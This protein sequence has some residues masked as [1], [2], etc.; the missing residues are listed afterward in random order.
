MERRIVLAKRPDLAI[1]LEK[2]DL[3]PNYN[4]ESPYRGCAK[5]WARDRIPPYD[6]PEYQALAERLP[7]GW[8]ELNESELEEVLLKLREKIDQ[9]KR[10]E[11][12]VPNK[13]GENA[14]RNLVHTAFLAITSAS[15]LLKEKGWEPL[16]NDDQK[17]VKDALEFS[18]ELSLRLFERAGILDRIFKFI[19]SAANLT[20]EDRALVQQVLKTSALFLVVFSASGGEREKLKFYFSNI[21]PLVYNGIVE[22]DRMVS[23]R[24]NEGKIRGELA[25]TTALFLRS[26]T[27]ALE[28]ADFDGFYA[29]FE[30]LLKQIGVDLEKLS[31]ETQEL[32]K[33]AD[34]VYDRINTGLEEQSVQKAMISQAM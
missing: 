28:K 27:H 29:G 19:A 13:G 11:T 4:R 22:V 10:V 5:R 21:L 17:A 15:I 9:Q 20:G 34:M 23:R 24:L 33:F 31:R 32:Q 12:A 3:L 7:V 16:S 6:Q 2:Y 1:Q 8:E 18:F 30:T 25:D 14:L 26:A